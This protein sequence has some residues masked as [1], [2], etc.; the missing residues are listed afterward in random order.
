MTNGMKYELALS[1]S[2]TFAQLFCKLHNFNP[3]F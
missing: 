1:V 3:I 2:L